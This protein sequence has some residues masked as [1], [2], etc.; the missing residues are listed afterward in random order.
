MEQAS[1][2]MDAT[3]IGSS[4]Y[5]SGKHSCQ[6]PPTLEY[7]LTIDNNPKQMDSLKFMNSLHV[8]A[9]YM[10]LDESYKGAVIV[11]QIKNNKDS[12]VVWKA[13]EIDAKRSNNWQ[14]ISSSIRFDNY[15]ITENDKVNVYVWNSQKKN[16][17]IDDIKLTYNG[18]K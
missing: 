10:I 2:F 6:L 11:F 5:S 14:N 15:R 17:A 16:I 4:Y 8:S 7:G 3:A 9:N 18:Y 12:V 1:D 13:I